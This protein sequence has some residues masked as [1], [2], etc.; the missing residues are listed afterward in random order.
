[1][2]PSPLPSGKRNR[3]RRLIFKDICSAQRRRFLQHQRFPQRR[4]R[5]PPGSVPQR[6]LR[7]CTPVVPQQSHNFRQPQLG[8]FRP[9]LRRRHQPQYRLFRQQLRLFSQQLRTELLGVSASFGR[10]PFRLVF[11]QQLRQEFILRQ[12]EQLRF[13]FIRKLQPQQLIFIRKLQPQQLIFLWKFQPQQ[14][15]HFQLLRQPQLLF[16]IFVPLRRLL[17][18]GRRQPQ[19]LLIRRTQIGRFRPS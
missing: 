3:L 6:L 4:F 10:I 9:Q 14:L 15:R 16:R 18:F 8:L 1:M 7:R 13:L 17:L 12:F 19:F 5:I 2:V 11:R